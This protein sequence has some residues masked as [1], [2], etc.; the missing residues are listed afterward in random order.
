MMNNQKI[1]S[2]SIIITDDK[3]VNLIKKKLSINLDSGITT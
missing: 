2:E 1:K 3:E